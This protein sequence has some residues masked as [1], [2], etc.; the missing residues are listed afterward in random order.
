MAFHAFH[1]LSFPWP[2]F[3]VWI[4]FT[5]EWAIVAH[6]WAGGRPGSTDCEDVLESH[7]R[8]HKFMKRGGFVKIIAQFLPLSLMLGTALGQ[9]TSPEQDLAIST[10]RSVSRLVIVP[11]IV[12]S[13]IGEFVPDL[14]PSDFELT[15]N[16]FPQKISLEESKDQGIAIVVLMQTGAAAP[17][18]FQKYR[19]L[20]NMLNVT[21]STSTHKVALVTFDSRP[22]QIW[23]F[24][25]RV[26][27]LEYAFAHPYSGD[28]GAA[29]MDAVESAIN[30]LQAQPS[31]LRRI[32]LLLSQ[33][34]DVG[35]KT[36]PHDVLRRLGES[37]TTVY[38]VSF[39][40]ESTSGEKEHAQT[41]SPSAAEQAQSF[42]HSNNVPFVILKGL[43]LDTAT[44]MALVSGGERIYV[45][46]EFDL[47]RSL[48]T[49][50]EDFSNAYTLSFRPSSSE[51][52][53][54]AISV[55]AGAQSSHFVVS[56]RKAYWL[57]KDA[58]PR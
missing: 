34:R 17:R 8:S 48:A 2:A 20:T 21:A 50:A 15:D 55:R 41:C 57:G 25:P 37:N 32:I 36:L 27:G 45:K 12:R 18:D 38:S 58:G 26:D 35:S 33:P 10:I 13:R 9:M 29:I 19:T 49:L 4:S 6:R 46:K 53:F 11:T 52:G 3:E 47:E 44:Q 7:A 56:A 30:L 54:H 14:G 39:P 28:S 31:S 5:A 1:T 24:P 42:G 40:P 51:L 16:G 22:Q 23:N 43:C